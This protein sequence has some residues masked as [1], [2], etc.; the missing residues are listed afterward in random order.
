MCM[1]RRTLYMGETLGSVLRRARTGRRLSQGAV[2]EQVG[3]SAW[4]SRV[5]ADRMLPDNAAVD[6]LLTSA[7]WGE[8]LRYS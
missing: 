8:S 2:G 7:R 5:E 4:V 1:D 3:Y 6:A